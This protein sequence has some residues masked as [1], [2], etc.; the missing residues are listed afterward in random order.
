M[1]VALQATTHWKSSTRRI[2]R[3]AVEH[4]LLDGF[5]DSKQGKHSKVFTIVENEDVK[6]A[7]LRYLRSLKPE[8]ITSEIFAS[9]LTEYLKREQY[10]K[11]DAQFND[12]TARRWLHKLNYRMYDYKQGLYYDGHERADVVWMPF[13]N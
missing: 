3:W 9:W 4:Y 1:E 13:Q 6:I 11:P 8:Q 10:I 7:C 5:I 2:R 12:R